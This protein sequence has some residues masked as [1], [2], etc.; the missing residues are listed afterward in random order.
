MG[1]FPRYVDT[2]GFMKVSTCCNACLEQDV[3]I[4]NAFDRQVGWRSAVRIQTAVEITREVILALDQPWK[5]CKGTQIQVIS[6]GGISVAALGATL[7][8][9]LSSSLSTMSGLGRRASSIDQGSTGDVLGRHLN[10]P[11][12]SKPFIQ[13]LERGLLHSDRLIGLLRVH[14]GEIGNTLF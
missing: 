2:V 7:A 13:D 10:A 6:V 1:L 4:V 11:F 12:E 9:R 3:G 14:S 5:H 8:I